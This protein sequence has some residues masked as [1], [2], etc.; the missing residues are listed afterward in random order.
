MKWPV[1]K[2]FDLKAHTHLLAQVGSHSHGTYIPPTQEGI[3]DIDI[4]GIVIPPKEFYLGLN[5]FE[6][7]CAWADEYDLTFYELR[8]F[9]NLLLKSNPNAM[10]LLWLTPNMYKIKTEVADL[11]IENRDIFSSKQAYKSFSGY[12]YSQLRKMENHACEGYMGAKRKELV[13]KF[14]YDTKN[15]AHLIR[16]LRMGMEFLSTGELNVMRHDSSQLIDIKKGLYK[17]QDIKEMA[18][19]LFKKTESAYLNSKLPTNPDFNKSNALL[20]EILES[21]ISTKV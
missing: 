7:H 1:F 12:A 3:D 21:Q 2:P 20:V 16:L 8:K 5:K 14:G 4:M 18:E 9:F 17:L 6:H 10:G 13:N 11:I 19:D 15:A